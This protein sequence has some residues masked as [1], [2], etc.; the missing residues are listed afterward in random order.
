MSDRLAR[1]NIIEDAGRQYAPIR[2]TDPFDDP[3]WLFDLKYDGFRALCRPG[4]R[5]GGD[6]SP[7]PVG[8]VPGQPGAASEQ[9]Q[10]M[11]CRELL[12][13]GFGKATQILAGDEERPH[14]IH[15]TW[16][17]AKAPE[18]EPATI[19]AEAKA[20]GVQTIALCWSDG[21]RV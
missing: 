17:D 21:T 5:S 16:V 20:D 9:A 7:R 6:R 4:A 2:R 14:R 1:A 19:E 11:A 8:R 3:E 15:F 18:L 10:I 12:D 13:R